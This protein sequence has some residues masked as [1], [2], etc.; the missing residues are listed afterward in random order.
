MME[1]M[2][3]NASAGYFVGVNLYTEKI[4]VMISMAVVTFLFGMMP[5]KL[6][7]AVRNNTDEA[8]RQRWK[9]IIS[10][11]S[12]FAGGVFIA[13]CLLDLFPDVQEQ[14]NSVLEQIKDKYHVDLDYPVSEFI[15]VLGFFLIL[16]IEQTVL[17]F[18]E[19]WI[20]EEEERAERQPLLGGGGNNRRYDSHQ[21]SHGSYQNDPP[22][23]QNGPGGGGGHH[24]HGQGDHQ[25][26]DLHVHVTPETT[27]LTGV[28]NE[29]HH[30]N[31]GH[32]D[33][34]HIS[35]GVFEHSALRSI[36][37]LIALSFHSVFEGLS[38]GLQKTN[39]QLISIFIAVI[40]HKA[41]MAF[42]LGLNIAQSNL[43]VKSF[44]VSNIIFSLASPIGLGIGIAVTDLPNTLPRE[45]A[46]GVLQGICGG[47]FLYITFFEVLP[48]EMNVPSNR[49][50]KVVFIILGYSGICGLLFIVH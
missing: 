10:F 3:V 2:T 20:A 17:H 44:V 7:S 15:I 34:N 45:I 16:L 39:D 26:D 32:S 19:S 36:L 12:C 1:N 13:A 49:L 50:W 9:T 8:S 25:H 40:V 29:V 38:I 31:D 43:S 42:S 48:H 5:I 23:Y 37:L 6:F 14:V 30:A 46:S 33:H 47:T 21:H 22:S 27:S 11:A 18:Q 35:H 28:S 24:Q 4:I 41:V